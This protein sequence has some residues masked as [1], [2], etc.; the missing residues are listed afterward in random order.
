VFDL[1]EF[2][3]AFKYVRVPIRDIS[4]LDQPVLFV[5]EAGH[6]QAL[7]H[8]LAGAVNLAHDKFAHDFMF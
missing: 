1:Q 5:V 7:L 8:C 3:D 4:D 6:L 2:L